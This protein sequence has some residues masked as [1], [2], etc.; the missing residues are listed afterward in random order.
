MPRRRESITRRQLRSR[1][2]PIRSDRR[3]RRPANLWREARASEGSARTVG[4]TVSKSAAVALA[5]TAGLAGAIAGYLAFAAPWSAGKV[6]GDS[7]AGRAVWTEVK[8][9]LPIDKWGK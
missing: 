1:R 6:T 4:R 9:R 3:S 7:S 2:M 5:L 8:R